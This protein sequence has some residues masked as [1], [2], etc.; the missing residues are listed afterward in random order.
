MGTNRRLKY[1]IEL[2]QIKEIFE[3]DQKPYIK[4]VDEILKAKRKSTD[5]SKLEKEIDEL[6]YTLYGITEE[7]KKIIEAG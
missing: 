5:T 6:V 7:E 3:K 1:K 2:L 4:L